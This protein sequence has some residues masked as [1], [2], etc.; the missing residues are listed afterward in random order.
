MY[1]NTYRHEILT[2]YSSDTATIASSAEPR[3]GGRKCLC[4]GWFWRS[5]LWNTIQMGKVWIVCPIYWHL[6]LEQ[7]RGDVWREGWPQLFFSA[8]FTVL[9]DLYLSCLVADPDQTMMKIH[10]TDWMMAEWKVINSS[11]RRLNFLICLRKYNLCCAFLCIASMCEVHYWSHS[12]ASTAHTVLRMAMGGSVGEF[13]SKVHSHLH[14]LERVQLQVVLTAPLDQVFYFLSVCK[15]ITVLEQSNDRDV[16]CIL[17][18]FQR[19]CPWEAAF[20]A[21]A[22]QL[23]EGGYQYWWSRRWMCRSPTSPDASRQSV[24]LLSTDSWRRAL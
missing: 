4:D 19:K 2:Q 17:Q 20:G 5:V 21:G 8:D 10:V 11:C 18:E 9:C 24:S 3:P 16:I 23:G 6:T 22:G 15:L 1:T 13:P 12:R 14:S 7:Y